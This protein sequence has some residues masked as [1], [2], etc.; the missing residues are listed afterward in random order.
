MA[1]ELGVERAPTGAGPS[2]DTRGPVTTGAAALAELDRP[3]LWAYGNSA[4]D[5]QMLAAADIGVD[6]GRLGRLGKLRRFRRLGDVL[7][8]W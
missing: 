8:A 6:T 2:R 3:F 7:T 4:G 5:R 1:R